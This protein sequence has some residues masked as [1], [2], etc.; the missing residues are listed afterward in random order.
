M[1]SCAITQKI[2]TQE[3]ATEKNRTKRAKRIKQ[4]LK[5]KKSFAQKIAP[6]PQKYNVHHYIILIL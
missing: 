2:P 5:P 1:E 6:L 3:K 4:D